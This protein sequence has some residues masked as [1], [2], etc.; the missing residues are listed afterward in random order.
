M[1][2]KNK[3]RSAFTLLE[4]IVVIAIIAI[5]AAVAVPKLSWYVDTAKQSTYVNTADAVYKA[6]TVFMVANPDFETNYKKYTTT[7]KFDYGMGLTYLKP[8][9][10]EPY[11]TGVPKVT[12]DEMAYLNDGYVR[13]EYCGNRPN[14]EYVWEIQ[15]GN[16]KKDNAQGKEYGRYYYDKK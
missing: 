14:E 11:L 15:I 1:T 13:I 10:I 7:D 6:I 12:S 5:L 16:S 4:L 8:E 3:K 9:Y 2:F